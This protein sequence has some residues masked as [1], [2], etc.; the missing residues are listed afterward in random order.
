MEFMGVKIEN[1]VFR[2]YKVVSS[3][4][5]QD[6]I[7]NRDYITNVNFDFIENEVTDRDKVLTID[8]T[9]SLLFEYDKL[10]QITVNLINLDSLARDVK[11][12]TD[13]KEYDIKE[14]VS[15]LGLGSDIL[16]VGGHEHCMFNNVIIR[17]LVDIDL[18]EL[19]IV[20]R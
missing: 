10:V 17:C 8:K 18:K 1:Q 9:I 12:I 5:L 19:T 14:I 3:E 7:K 16:I 2:W 13:N 20:R 4:I 15:L 11:F 6:F